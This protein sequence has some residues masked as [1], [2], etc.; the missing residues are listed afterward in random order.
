MNE[1][2]ALT[3]I[4]LTAETALQVEVKLKA[5]K[6]VLNGRAGYSLWYDDHTLGT[7]LAIVEVKRQGAYS[8]NSCTWV[9]TPSD[10]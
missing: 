8:D 2:H 4:S 1:E 3:P 5:Q 7:N 10:L 6:R 9:G